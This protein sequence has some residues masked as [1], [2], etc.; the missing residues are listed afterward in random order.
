M[1]KPAL[2]SLLFLSK[3]KCQALK[4]SYQPASTRVF[5]LQRFFNLLVNNE[6]ILCCTNKYVA[7]LSYNINS[8]FLYILNPFLYLSV[9]PSGIF[10]IGIVLK[11]LRRQRCSSNNSQIPYNEWINRLICVPVRPSNCYTQVN[12]N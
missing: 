2:I 1:A 6:H 4:T 10:N 3:W 7:M 12:T 8:I 5:F 9:N 11:C